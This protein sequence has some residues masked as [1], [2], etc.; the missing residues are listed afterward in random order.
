MERIKRETGKPFGAGTTRK[1]WEDLVRNGL[2]DE[3]SQSGG[4]EGDNE[5]GNMEEDSSSD[6]FESFSVSD[7]EPSFGASFNND[8]GDDDDFPG[9]ASQLSPGGRPI[10]WE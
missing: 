5:D 8:Q 7:N 3:H 9:G 2:L 4:E 6:V 1:K 10:Y